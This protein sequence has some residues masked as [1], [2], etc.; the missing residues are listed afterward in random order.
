MTDR[1]IPA[2]SDEAAQ[3]TVIEAFRQVLGITEVDPEAPF[4]A[5]GGDSLRAVRVLSRVWRELGVELPVHALGETTT[6]AE[7]AAVVRERGGTP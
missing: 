7:F 6:A 2:I 4:G 3:A 1:S 5:L